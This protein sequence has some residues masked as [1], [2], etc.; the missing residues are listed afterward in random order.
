MSWYI[1][2]EEKALNDFPNRNMVSRTYTLDEGD[3]ITSSREVSYRF[4]VNGA[5]TNDIGMFKT[6]T[7]IIEQQA[8]GEG[9]RSINNRNEIII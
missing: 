3:K 7:F 1:N 9:G 6:F 8:M 4:Q 2:R 5:K